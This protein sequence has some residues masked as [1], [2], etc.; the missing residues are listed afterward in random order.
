MLGNTC[1]NADSRKYL[2]NLM[3]WG[4]EKMKRVDKKAIYAKYGIEYKDGKILCPI[5]NGTWIRPLLVDGN[6]KIGKGAYHFSIL[7]TSRE[8]RIDINGTERIVKG[9]C[10]CTCM[11]SS[12][13]ITCYA[14]KGNYVFSSVVRSLAIKTILSYEYMKF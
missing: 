13:E 4:I 11:N 12:G 5:D 7:P 8:Y 9:T 10:P 6:K 1:Y 14:T 2:F 3:N